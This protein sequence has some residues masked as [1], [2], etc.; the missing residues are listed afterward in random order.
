MVYF[1][2]ETK[3]HFSRGLPLLLG[4]LIATLA[5]WTLLTNTSLLLAVMLQGSVLFALTHLMC[6]MD[7]FLLNKLNSETIVKLKYGC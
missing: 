6:K 1:F 2:I 7:H 5:G 4:K 3:M